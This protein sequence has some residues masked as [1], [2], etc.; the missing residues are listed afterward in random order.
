MQL[1]L[2][3]Q[4]TT[5]SGCN[6]ASPFP[7][8]GEC[9]S[10][11]VSPR[12]TAYMIYVGS[13]LEA[14]VHGIR[15]NGSIS[16]CRI[17][18]YPSICCLYQ[19]SPFVFSHKRIELNIYPTKAAET[20]YMYQTTPTTNSLWEVKNTDGRSCWCYLYSM[21]NRWA[22]NINV[23]LTCSSQNKCWFNFNADLCNLLLQSPQCMHMQEC[24]DE[25]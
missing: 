17:P 19:K 15:R 7:D 10:I 6:A 18:S 8:R 23:C 5:G 11:G 14:W 16:R 25:Q 9:D 20:P 12:M 24:L 1:L 2:R 13:T 22:T 4:S 3:E 21:I